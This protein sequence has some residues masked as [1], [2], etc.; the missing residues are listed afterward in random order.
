MN[1]RYY[2][3]TPIFYVNGSPHVGHAYSAIAAD[4]LAR[5]HRLDGDDVFF[6]TGTDEYG[7]KVEQTAR[8]LG[9]EP[10][11][12]ADKNSAEFQDVAR[13]LNISN[14]DFIRT[15]QPRHHR[16]CAALWNRLFEAGEI[17]LGEYSGWYSMRDE[18]FY[19][20][21][22]LL[23]K[24]GKRVSP[25]GS[26]VELVR[27]PNYLFRLSHWQDRLLA[28]YE[29]NPDFLGPS[30]SRSEVLSFVRDGLTDLS[31]SRKNFRWGV[32]V[33]NDP[34]HVMYVWLDALTNYLTA[35]GWPETDG[36]R[37]AFWP[38]NVHLVGKEIVRFHAVY[39]PAFLMA[40]GVPVPKRVF[41]GGWWTVEGEKM[42]KSIG[43]VI[44][45]RVLVE[46]FGLD[47]LRFFLLREMPFGNDGDF[48]RRALIG[49]MNSE[50]ANDLGNLAQ[51]SLSLIA[52]NC[53]GVLPPVGPGTDDDADL[54]AQTA[55]LPGLMRV[56]LARQAFGEALED[57][58]KVIRAANSY[59][60]RQA[61]WVLRKT[62]P[63]RME[64]VLRVLADIIRGVATVLQPFMPGSMG[65]MLDQS[66]VPA[67][68]RSLADLAVPLPGGVQLPPPQ[69]VFP[70]FVE[71]AA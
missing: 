46:E 56:S 63:A 36:P 8:D 32:P 71:T 2:I 35:T 13:V 59:I 62:D 69:G 1:D 30:S 21:D 27:E 70:R 49:R 12:L 39:W 20:E 25:F 58:W 65:A 18:A 45:P 14:D 9:V 68:A 17:Y 52:K 53:G 31:V 55:A 23:E 4:V 54:R 37:A 3:T 64:A 24:D 42:S 44:D 5:W 19:A 26:P 28:F 61:P 29:A 41:A 10:Q 43:N 22:E 11:A 67:D 38:A 51:R 33:P 66:G 60:D 34:A 15:T 7:Q 40:A 48:N 16:T 47:P 50:L 57:V 6:L